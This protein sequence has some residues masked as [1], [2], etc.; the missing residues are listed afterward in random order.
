[1]NQLLGNVLAAMFGGPPQDNLDASRDP[2]TGELT[3]PPMRTPGLGEKIFDSDTARQEASINTQWK[4]AK[5]QAEYQ[6]DIDRDI[7]G[8]QID[9]QPYQNNPLLGAY[10]SPKAN[11]TIPTVGNSGM[12]MGLADH[13]APEDYH[14]FTSGSPTNANVFNEN[15]MGKERAG[16]VDQ[17]INPRL[18][19]A[20]LEPN[21]VSQSSM[22][23]GLPP[24][25]AATQAST[26]NILANTDN[27]QARFESENQPQSQNLYL[28][29]QTNAGHSA[30]NDAIMLSNMN[31]KFLAEHGRLPT[32]N[33]TAALQA[34]FDRNAAQFGV[35]EQGINLGTQALE[36]R[37]RNYNA[38]IIP[39]RGGDTPFAAKVNSLG[40]EEM[41]GISPAY[42]NMLQLINAKSGAGG[43]GGV[44][45]PSGGSFIPPQGE[46]KEIGPSI[47]GANPDT[48]SGAGA[49]GKGSGETYKHPDAISGDQNID[50]LVAAAKDELDKNGGKPTPLYK[51]ITDLLH[52][53][54]Q[55]ALYSQKR[56]L[57]TQR[58]GEGAIPSYW[59]EG[60]LTGMN[61]EPQVYNPFVG[62]PVAAGQME[63]ALE[64][65][66][67]G[68]IRK[69]TNLVTHGNP[70]GTGDS[71]YDYLFNQ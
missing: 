50:S 20:S 28:K 7:A 23:T 39:I 30:D 15:L 10:G 14:N 44:T 2:V 35:N 47:Y 6:L 65:H 36:D 18:S 27:R 45:T 55:Q 25:T 17:T 34:T 57:Q 11:D 29:Q 1:M 69:L 19:S 67:K 32:E 49:V 52:E 54:H 61:G 58:V 8:K 70:E 43:V 13:A 63:A 41:P 66:F 31:S 68:G 48:T 59:R 4:L 62:L 33:E 60:S 12:F 9:T 51:H 24:R 42:H 21:V 53:A 37:A 22:N 71:L 5:P 3:A 56:Q 16:W 38:G 40:V 46:G 26:Q 64:P